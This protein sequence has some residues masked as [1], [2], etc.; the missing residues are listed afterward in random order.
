MRKAYEKEGYKSTAYNKA[1]HAISEDLMTIRFT[2]KTIERLCNILRSQVDDL[3]R[4][5]R[6]IRKIVVDKCGMPQDHFIKT[7]PPN[8]LNLKWAEK[9]IAPR[10]S[11]TARCWR[12]TCRRCR[13]CSRS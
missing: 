3:R 6:E 11:R 9:E 4:Y 7:F 5:E 10:P 13:N 1:Q 8:V 12:A 2:V